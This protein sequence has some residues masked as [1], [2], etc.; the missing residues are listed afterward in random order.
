[1]KTMH[2]ATILAIDDDAIIRQSLKDYLEDIHFRVLEAADGSRG[3]DIFQS[4]EPDLVLLDLRM[5]EMDGL[6][7][8]AKIRQ[9]APD[10]PV[11]VVSGTGLMADVVDALHLGAW[12]FVLKPIEDMSVL[13]HTVKKVLERARLIRENH[14][15]QEHLEKEVTKRTEE[16]EQ[17]NRALYASEERFRELAEL[18]P[19]A[20]Y[21]MDIE[22]KFTFANHKAFDRFGYTQED[23]DRGIN[24]FDLIVSGDRERA[25]ANVNRI[26]R[27]ENIGLQE[28]TMSRKDG[29]T[30][31][32]L[33]R[34]EVIFH[35]NEPIGF[36]GVAIDITDQ[37]RLEAQLRQ[38]QKMEAIG[39]LAG[40]I[41]HDF[42][43]ILSAIIG[44]TE[45]AINDVGEETRLYNKLQ[46]V[47]NAG[48]RAK[49]LVEQILTF[50]RQKEQELMP[51]QI[52]LVV[53]EALKLLRA[54][55]PT[56]V[57]INQ[58][59]R[60]DSL[61]MGDPTQIHQVLMNLCTNANHAMREKGGVL[62][63]QLGDVELDSEFA[64]VHPDI[65][66][67]QYV[68]LMVNDTGYGM[69]QDVLNR[70]FD[71]FF[72]TKEPGEG[73]GMGLSVVH[74]I[75]KSHDGTIMVYSEPG[76]GSTFKVFLPAI[77]MDFEPEI[78]DEKPIPMGS[79]HILFIDDEPAIAEWG[80]QAIESLGYNV[81]IKTSSID[82][83]A[84]FKKD[85][86]AFDLVIT[87][88]TMPN[89]AG[90]RLS[91]EFLDIQPD[92]P[93]ILCTGFSSKITEKKIR[94]AG[95]RALLEKPFVKRTIGETIRKVLDEK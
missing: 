21:E 53:R 11:I 27:E 56:T 62:T 34:S 4:E 66:P 12:D 35:D 88:M 46:H 61:V 68:E 43:N 86:N 19:E 59:I 8:L 24:G 36:R 26:L 63:V 76:K 30:F 81:T 94:G 38:A 67:G 64:V 73:T 10:S 52:K 33:L 3:I 78:R 90:D 37:K 42:N 9:I 14:L 31:P 2:S 89:M 58:T 17:S 75:V 25:R 82:A 51:V 72:T 85:P 49:N 5:P 80:K 23:F 83:L 93:I 79:E 6:E 65:K 50:S 87:D 70:I 44:F 47:L 74:G 16:L 92:M 1:M 7:V 22:G 95:I 48:D 18:L 60:S 71:P 28:Y 15:Y 13:G 45:L 41:A 91:K 20:I 77:E 84:L 32:V 57:E 40:G 29:H 55:L 69:S 54:S 39:T